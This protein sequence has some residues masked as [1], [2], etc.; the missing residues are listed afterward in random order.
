MWVSSMT[1]ILIEEKSLETDQCTVTT[2]RSWKFNKP[3]RMASKEP[4]SANTLIADLTPTLRGKYPYCLSHLGLCWS[5]PSKLVQCGDGMGMFVIYLLGRR[6]QREQVACQITT[7]T[8]NANGVEVLAR[9]QYEI[10]NHP[11]LE[12]Y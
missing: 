9:K 1:H 3:G 4:S 8:S 6:A 10:R 12:T 5:I 7:L 2:W 11:D